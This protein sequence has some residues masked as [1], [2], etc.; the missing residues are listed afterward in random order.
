MQR[1]QR[2]SR[3]APVTRRFMRPNACKLHD[4]QKHGQPV[5]NDAGLVETI[6]SVRGCNDRFRF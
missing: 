4:D 1:Q 5:Q 3:V 6:V 2:R